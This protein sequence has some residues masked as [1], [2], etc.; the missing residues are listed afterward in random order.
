MIKKKY[1]TTPSRHTLSR[2]TLLKGVASMMAAPAILKYSRA[3]AAT[4]VIKIGLVSSQSGV[5]QNFGAADAYIIDTIEKTFK[6][7]IENN[8]KAYEI[9]IITK[10]SQSVSNL[11]SEAAADLI[12]DEEVDIIIAASTPKNVNPVADQAEINE[13]PCI[14]TCCPWQPYFFGRNGNPAEGFEYSY[15][16]FWGLE[17]II[18]S[19]LSLWKD[20]AVTKSVGALFPNDSDGNAWGDPELGLPTPLAAAGY[21]LIDP[22][23]FE[24]FTPDFSAQI[25]AFKESGCEIITGNM[26]TT[27]FINFW[28]QAK[29][30]DFHPKIVTIGKALLF[31]TAI[32]KLGAY[33]EGLTSEIWWSPDHPYRSSLTGQSARELADSYSLMTNRPWTQPLGFQHALFEIVANVISRAE[34]LSDPSAIAHAIAD[35][36]METIIGTVNWKNGPVPNISKTALVGGQWQKLPNGKM[37]LKIVNNAQAPHVP[38]TGELML[39]R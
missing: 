25:A 18:K 31:Q 35:T 19:F 30:Q 20:S 36:N 23:R 4:P 10:D 15:H 39:M 17:D 7:G 3:Y 8:G 14:T 11:A 34:D 21:H 9:Q 32:A 29:Q 28:T 16:F 38:V 13:V 33:G 37:D 22:G 1:A 12:L 6:K 5:F 26:I 2:R 27:D 24:P